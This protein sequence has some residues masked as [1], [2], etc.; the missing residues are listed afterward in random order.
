MLLI[1]KIVLL[2]HNLSTAGG[3]SVGQNI[4]HILPVIAPMHEYLIFVPE[5]CGYP[6]FEGHSNITVKCC[7][8][9]GLLSR[10]QWEKKVMFPSIKSFDPEWIWAL[11]NIGLPKPPCP[12]SVLFHILHYLYH[13][14]HY[15]YSKGELLLKKIFLLPLQKYYIKKGFKVSHRV[16]C[17]TETARIRL[18]KSFDYPLHQI[19]ICPNAVSFSVQKSNTIPP[20]LTKHKG[21]FILFVLTKYYAHKNLERIVDVFKSFPAELKDVVCVMPIRPDQGKRAAQLVARTEKAG[22]SKKIV[23]V[24]PIPQDRL[25]EF[26]HAADVMFLPTL[27]ESFSGTYL[28]AMH[29]DTPILTSDLDFARETCGPA[30]EYVDPFSL[31]S[32][33]DG[34]LK[35]KNDQE[36][37]KE[38]IRLG[39]QQQ[40]LY[41]KSWEEILK[42]VLDQEG[43][44]Y[45][46]CG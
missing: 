23:F 36:R 39:S 3:K 38:L 40:L 26:F 31:E 22:L 28:E 35:L 19:K 17:Q 41:G 2:A 33:R 27:L 21:K 10:W 46:L 4:V 44:P 13:H 29:L 9:D 11:G 15:G 1:M 25:G 34:I 32:M 7:P 5:N 14:T 24:D 37:R 45:D 43:I 20:E 42:S 6:K 18:N 12:Q 16:Y 8:Q 30:A